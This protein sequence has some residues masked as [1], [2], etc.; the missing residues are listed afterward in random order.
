MRW[1]CRGSLFSR[2]TGLGES[3]LCWLCDDDEGWV[4]GLEV[5]EGLFPIF[6]R[7]GTGTEP[8]KES[9]SRCKSERAE[10][11]IKVRSCLLLRDGDGHV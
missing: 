3:L 6:T 1:P 2:F 5:E 9:K 11:Y 8:E 7:E 4:A 10:D